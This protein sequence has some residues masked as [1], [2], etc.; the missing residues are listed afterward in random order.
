MTRLALLALLCCVVAAAASEAQPNLLSLAKT[1]PQAAFTS[2]LRQHGKENERNLG[3]RFE[4]FKTNVEFIHSYNAQH[5]ASHQ[6]EL[7]EYADMSWE[8]FAR[9]RLGFDA[10]KQAESLRSRG[11]TPFRHA[12][13][14]PPAAVDWREK[15][16]VTGVK[17]QGACGSCWAFSATGAVEGI[18]KIKTGELVSLSE[19]QL[20]DCDTVT[21]NAG[22]GG[23]LMDWAFEYIK[24]NGGIDTEDDWGY[25][26]GWGFGT[27]CNKR[28]LTDR[29]AVTI[30]GYE[31]V[32]KNDE[33]ALKQAISQQ[34]V[35]VGICASPAMQFYSG[36]VI[37]TCCDELNHGVLAVGYGTDEATGHP[38]YL[39]KN[40]WGGSWGEKGFFRLKYGTSKEG[41]CGIATTASYPVKKSATNPAVPS[42]C[43]PFGWAE[44]PVGATCS[45]SWPFFFNLFCIR[46]DCCPLRG[47]VGCADNSHCC[48]A[49]APVCDTQAGTCS[50][51]D[52]SKTV[53]WTA[54]NPADYDFTGSSSSSDKSVAP[55]VSEMARMYRSMHKMQM[56]SN[57]QKPQG[58][59][60]QQQ[61]QQQVQE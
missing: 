4:T 60:Q 46:H 3:A 31:D 23:G 37:D 16:A 59:L 20:V 36:G 13:A 27:W 52:G 35:A 7:N 33:Y 2:W 8:V 9:T 54:K 17:N 40:S 12:N 21:G 41:L 42:M 15:G 55:S 32:P 49:D 25:Y 1:N 39:I 48:P 18:N 47:G 6:L 28:K 19:Q 44:C 45:C 38:Y 61:Q 50:S 14:N 5:G 24:N 11:P 51:T 29:H 10:T 34:P 26:S 43:D 57:P 53:Q 56:M 58:I 22:C 30:D